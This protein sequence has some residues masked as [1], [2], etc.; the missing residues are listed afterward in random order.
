MKRLILFSLF[1]LV[2]CVSSP[3]YRIDSVSDEELAIAKEEIQSTSVKKSRAF[4]WRKVNRLKKVINRLDAPSKKICYALGENSSPH[5][6]NWEIDYNYD[7]SINAFATINRNG[8]NI[9]S[10][11]QGVLDYSKNEDELALLVAHE[12]AHHISNHVMDRLTNKN[13]LG[14]GLGI[15]VG[16]A[17]VANSDA[18]VTIDNIDTAINI[19]EGTK[20]IGETLS[21]PK[22][23]RKQEAEADLIAIQILDDAGY[24]LDKSKNFFLTSFALMESSQISADFFDSHPSG[25]SRVAA[26]NKAMDEKNRSKIIQKIDNWCS[27]RNIFD[28]WKYG[29]Y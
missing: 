23:N 16:L 29:C 7:Q 25:P 28:R 19:V 4:G 22:F 12:I 9:V 15:L 11:N 5:G 13:T 27:K 21:R 14:E 26:M 18:D 2:G 20:K 10:I 17:I 1:F 8:L 24:D 6:C 3:E